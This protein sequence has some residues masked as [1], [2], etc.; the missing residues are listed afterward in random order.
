ML[1][2][3]VS[4]SPVNCQVA[5][6]VPD[7]EGELPEWP[8]A[9]QPPVVATAECLYVRTICDVDG[10]VNV[11]AWWGELPAGLG[12]PVYEGPF[13]VYRAG[14]LAGSWTGNHL[15]HLLLREGQYQVRVYASPRGELADRVVFVLDSVDAG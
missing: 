2:A 5:L 10:L 6:F 9:S 11:E 1:L 7:G 15:A 8:A 13:V 12:A 4:V 3:Q 14:A